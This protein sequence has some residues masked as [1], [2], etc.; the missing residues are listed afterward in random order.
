M[1]R[2]ALADAARLMSQVQYKMALPGRMSL[3]H[4]PQITMRKGGGAYPK[5]GGAYHYPLRRFADVHAKLV[6]CTC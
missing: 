5:G 4:R 6:A 2:Q 3:D 1:G